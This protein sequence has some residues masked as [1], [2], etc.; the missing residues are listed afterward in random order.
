MSD[1]SEEDD[2]IQQENVYDI[3]D[4]IQDW[5]FLNNKSNIPKRG[6]K[7]FEPDG[8]TIQSSA[9]Q[10]SQNAMFNAL[11]NIRGHHSKNKLLGVLIPTEEEEE[12]EYWCFIE[13]VRGN[14][15]KDLGKGYKLGEIHGM[16]LNNLETIYLA[17]RG[18]LIVYLGNKEYLNWLNNPNQQQEQLQQ[19][20]KFNIEEKLPVLDLE[21]LYCLL[22]IPLAKYQVYAYLKRLGY[23]LQ[24]YSSSSEP[25][26]KTNESNL[27]NKTNKPN[28]NKK[29]NEFIS[30]PREW[31]ILSYPLFHSLHFKTK[32]YFN[33]TDV[34]KSIKLNTK[35]IDYKPANNSI[36]ITFNVWKP[37]PNFS[38]K[39]PPI[40]DFQLCVI[41]C[42]KNTQFLTLSQIQSLQIQL[43]PTD[44]SNRV[45]PKL[46]NS[47]AKK[48]ESKKEIRAKQYAERQLKLDKSIQLRNEY[49][50][51][52]DLLFKNGENSIIISIVNNGIINF[53]NLSQGQFNSLELNSRLNEIYP[54]KPHSIICN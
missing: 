51:S 24:D 13:Q 14:Y 34:F 7:E 10:I 54:N 19:L 26:I 15:F 50:K 49:F 31:G 45:V 52:R 40:P 46:N 27:N 2:Q 48:M 42:S 20:D 39:N 5:K 1:G 6:E 16:K 38:K 4:E 30:W 18:S 22:N 36:D 21:Y 44:I 41:D 47:K 35:P 43:N 11:E 9:L 28:L 8:T 29:S 53:I 37:I 17:E 32:H 25:I 12:G 33:Y 23:I 3:E